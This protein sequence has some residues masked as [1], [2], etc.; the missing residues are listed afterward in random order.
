ML[1]RGLRALSLYCASGCSDVQDLVTD[2]ITPGICNPPNPLVAACFTS[3]LSRRLAPR[4][5][6]S[7]ERDEAL[8]ECARLRRLVAAERR[9]SDA[10]H[11]SPDPCADPRAS[12]DPR[13][14]MGRA[15]STGGAGGSVASAATTGAAAL[16]E[17]GLTATDGGQAS[18]GG[19]GTRTDGSWAGWGAS[20]DKDV[21]VVELRDQ[22]A[23]ARDDTT[24]FSY[25]LQFF[26]SFLQSCCFGNCADTLPPHHAAP[27]VCDLS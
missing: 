14:S 2:A 6:V 16:L 8:V 20:A 4:A 15:S 13:A 17:C 12:T 26:A 25:L 22:V 9:A 18:G 23:A 7:A 11:R 27:S 1:R 10:A 19:S 21:L 24:A 3:F 5:Q